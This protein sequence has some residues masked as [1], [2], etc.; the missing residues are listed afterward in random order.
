MKSA[1]L[2]HLRLF[3]L[4][5]VTLCVAAASHP[6]SV[7]RVGVALAREAPVAGAAELA[8]GSTVTRTLA[9]GG[10]HSFYVRLDADQSLRVSLFKGDFDLLLTVYDAA[11]RE[12]RRLVS[13]RFGPLEF[14]F[15]A[16]AGGP[17]KIEVRSA[18]KD[19]VERGFALT[20]GAAQPAGAD[21]RLEDEAGRAFSEAEMLRAEWKEDSL[22]GAVERYGEAWRRW[23]GASRHA[24]AAAALGGTGD[25]Y[26]T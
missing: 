7:K 26:F 6:D 2:S 12:V 20:L 21:E 16:V 8:P 17:H 10:A 14:S 24:E 22:R 3:I 13:R 25:V 1:N 4:L 15:V 19:S 9:G 18:E 5:T 11:G 23:R